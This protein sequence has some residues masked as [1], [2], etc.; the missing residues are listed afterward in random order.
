MRAS[1]PHAGWPTTPCAAQKP[2][3]RRWR[4]ARVTCWARADL[5][6]PEISYS[7]L[8]PRFFFFFFFFKALFPHQHLLQHE[9]HHHHYYHHH[10]TYA[11]TVS[12]WTTSS[13]CTNIIYENSAKWDW[14]AG[15]S[16][17]FYRLALKCRRYLIY[18]R[19]VS[20]RRNVLQQMNF[21]RDK[22]RETERDRDRLKSESAIFSIKISRK[23][24]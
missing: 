19:S 5:L 8:C 13:S 9:H 16:S 21:G 15:L 11:D 2:A 17:I 10:Y 1:G 14:Q 4:P 6:S 23:E 24:K 22:Q 18:M 20:Y 12:R 7:F 3:V